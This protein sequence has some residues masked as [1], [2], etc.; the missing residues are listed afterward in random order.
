MIYQ[1]TWNQRDLSHE[2]E[3]SDQILHPLMS[4]DMPSLPA[5]KKRQMPG[6]ARGDVE[7]SIWLVHNYGFYRVQNNSLWRS[8]QLSRGCDNLWSRILLIG[9][10]KE[11]ILNDNSRSKFKYS[12]F[13]MPRQ[14]LP[15]P[16]AKFLYLLNLWNLTETGSRLSV[17]RDDWKSGGQRTGSR[18]PPVT[19]PARRSSTFSIAPTDRKP[20]TG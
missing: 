8:L 4:G 18:I 7:A 9:I 10:S 13:K 11:T 14:L 3:A 5:R 17:S 19:D 20:R 12:S 1:P 15:L 6:Y 2:I 16:H